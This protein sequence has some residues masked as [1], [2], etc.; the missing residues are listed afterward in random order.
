MVKMEHSVVINRPIEE[1]FA[2]LTR[3]ENGLQFRAG[4]LEAEQTSEGPMGVGTTWREVEQF[5][6]RRSEST[7]EVTQYEPNTRLRFR[8]TSGP[9]PAEATETFELVEGGTRV[10]V[11][12][13]VE[14]GGL[15]KLAEPVVAR[16]AKRQVEADI[17][18]AKDLL[19]AQTES[20]A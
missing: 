1:V 15:F 12:F 11:T 13:E 2:F 16:M 6:G 19:E 4:L 18:N 7:Y 14:L 5:L 8:S 17:G 9:M 20:N 10:N 3:P